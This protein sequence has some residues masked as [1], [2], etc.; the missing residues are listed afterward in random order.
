MYARP[1]PIF[2]RNKDMLDMSFTKGRTSLQ[3]KSGQFTQPGP[4]Q[5]PKIHLSSK[6]HSLSLCY[7]LKSTFEGVVECP[8]NMSPFVRI[9][10]GPGHPPFP[11][12]CAAPGQ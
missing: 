6:R 8:P 4:S 7:F 5:H 9:S 10:G 2:L 11:L 3:C 12:S 1:I